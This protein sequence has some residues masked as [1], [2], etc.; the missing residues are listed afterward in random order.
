MLALIIFAA[1]KNLFYFTIM[2]RLISY[3][4]MAFVMVTGLSA[5]NLVFSQICTVSDQ[6][7]ISPVYGDD[8]FFPLDRSRFTAPLEV[9]HLYTV[10][11]VFSST[12]SITFTSC[13]ELQLDNSDNPEE[14]F[15]LDRGSLYAS[16]GSVYIGNISCD[17]EY[18]D[19]GMDNYPPG[20]NGDWMP[21]DYYHFEVTS[22]FFIRLYGCYYDT[23][24]TVNIYE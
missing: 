11:I 6:D 14:T 16:D 4:L 13:Y 3:C 22:G 17:E 5:E 10:S 19:D 18:E 15:I 9:G 7:E 23:T 2:K 1:I 20:S 12:D 21:E 24:F 8:S